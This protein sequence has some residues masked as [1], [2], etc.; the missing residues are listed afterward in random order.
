MTYPA[1]TNAAGTPWESAFSQANW[2]ASS[3]GYCGQLYNPSQIIRT[4]SSSATA[5]LDTSKASKTGAT[6]SVN[7]GY[8]ELYEQH[9][10]STIGLHQSVNQPDFHGA[11]AI[12]GD[13][14][15][16]TTTWPQSNTIK[17]G[18]SSDGCDALRNLGIFKFPAGSHSATI[19]FSYKSGTI[20]VRPVRWYFEVLRL[21]NVP[22]NPLTLQEQ[23]MGS[24]HGRNNRHVQPEL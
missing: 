20:G 11:T 14:L 18:G 10:N 3:G 21:A 19:K 6:V 4:E 24:S 7:G 13:L 17:S 16:D 12:S 23:A 5:T 8:Y 22:A 1:C 15:R 9:Y 2:L